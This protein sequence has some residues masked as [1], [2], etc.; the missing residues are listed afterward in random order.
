[1]ASRRVHRGN[2][3][4]E[5]EREPQYQN[6]E[7]NLDL[8]RRDI[9]AALSNAF[10]R[11][12]RRR[13][14]ERAQRRAHRSERSIREEE[15]LTNAS[16]RSKTGR[17]GSTRVKIRY[18]ME[19][20][21]E[22]ESDI[23]NSTEKNDHSRWRIGT[24]RASRRKEK[25]VGHRSK[26]LDGHYKKDRGLDLKIAC[27]IFKGKKHVDP[28]VHIQAFAQYAEMKHIL[29]EEL[30][31]Y[32][33]HTLKEAAKKCSTS[34]P[35][36]AHAHK[37]CQKQKLKRGLWSPD[38]DEKLLTCIMQHGPGSW[39][40]VPTLAG[41]QR[42]GKSCRLRWINYLRPDLKRGSFS[43]GEEK[44]IIELHAIFG[45]K[46]SK[47][48]SH[49]PGRTDN[50]IK[51]LWN[52]CL[53]KRVEKKIA[54][55]NDVANKAVNA[56]DVIK[57]RKAGLVAVRPCPIT[58]A[59]SPCMPSGPIFPF[60]HVDFVDNNAQCRESVFQASHNMAVKPLDHNPIANGNDSEHTALHH[61][62][63]NHDQLLDTINMPRQEADQFLVR[64]AQLPDFKR[65]QSRETLDEVVIV[66]NNASAQMSS[67]QPVDIKD[68]QENSLPS[69]GYDRGFV[70]GWFTRF[71]DPTRKACA[72][73]RQNNHI[74]SFIKINKVNQKEFHSDDERTDTDKDY[75]SDESIKE[76][77]Q[78]GA[79]AKG[80]FEH[81]RS[82]KED[83]STPLDKESKKP[84]TTEQILMDEAMTSIE[85]R[86]KELADARA[87]KAAKTSKPTTME[88]ARKLRLEKAKA[89]Q[90]E[91]RRLEA[92]KKAQEEAT[93]AQVAQTKEKEVIDLFGTIE[94]LKNIERE[95]HLEEQRAAQ[96]ARE[97]I[98]EALSRKAEGPILEPSQGSPKRPRQ[99]DEEELEHKQA[100]L[101][102]SSPMS[103]PLTP[104]SSPITLFPPQEHLHHRE[105][106]IHQDHHLLSPLLNS[107]NNLLN[108]L[109]FHP[110][111]NH[112]T[113]KS[114]NKKIKQI[115]K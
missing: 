96:L 36:M 86:K 64:L 46:W 82:D 71:F 115:K 2:D 49:L 34:A 29:E 110:L 92:E 33:P 45:N 109:K 81:E 91:R 31:E 68:N 41:I 58:A 1:M 106:L 53:K 37:C 75:D 39:S 102:P 43:T 78:K 13:T 65:L 73:S 50:E 108:Q 14:A 7:K 67:L 94:Y 70:S 42:C 69:F 5:T 95:K 104:P 56:H 21:I 26:T 40:S 32:F 51:N 15:D 66:P 55:S 77:N 97:K 107:S 48:A 111:H 59:S 38:E 89:L 30:G 22:F 18:H 113:S 63:I 93:A 61:K 27:P 74:S 8:G 10:A 90:E 80:P 76:D 6:E 112:K 47:I 24:G 100:D 54:Q 98:K 28:D 88:E 72:Q 57:S 101:P 84:K 17:D 20:V 44:R 79:E 62:L 23:G 52:S 83:T 85:A 11:S 3:G 9:E 19:R 25:S 103:I 105:L 99:E 16:R 12:S 4:T 87:A 114:I 60:S 35:S